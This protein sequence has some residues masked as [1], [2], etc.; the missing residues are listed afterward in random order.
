M[1]MRLV[2]DAERA[3]SG[4]ALEGP[5]RIAAGGVGQVFAMRALLQ[6]RQQL[7]GIR[8]ALSTPDPAAVAGQLLRG[9]LDLVVASFVVSNE[10]L[11]TDLLTY[12]TSSVYCGPAHPLYGRTEVSIDEIQSHPFTA[13]PAG[14]DGWPAELA[15]DIEMTAD[16]MQAGLQICGSTTLLAVIPDAFAATSAIQLHRLPIEGLIPKTPVVAT[17]RNPTGADDLTERLVQLLGRITKG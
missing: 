8:P 4:A 7:P 2:D 15:R 14:A 12:A 5:I 16:R 9:D 3:V 10:G 1:A 6:A 13:P 17:R 11:Q